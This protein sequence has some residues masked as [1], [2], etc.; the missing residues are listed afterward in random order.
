MVVHEEI[1]EKVFGAECST[2][3]RKFGVTRATTQQSRHKNP[4]N[5]AEPRD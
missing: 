5:Y 4:L 3:T 1:K 2:N